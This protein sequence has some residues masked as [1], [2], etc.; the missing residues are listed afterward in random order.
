[1]QC[2]IRT[3]LINFGYKKRYYTRQNCLSLAWRNYTYFT[4][5]K[6]NYLLSVSCSTFWV[7]ESTVLIFPSSWKWNLFRFDAPKCKGGDESERIKL[8]SIKIIDFQLMVIEASYYLHEWSS[9]SLLIKESKNL[10]LK[11]QSP[12]VNF[13]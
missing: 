11:T 6:K 9:S 8:F 4:G 13:L 5:L 7:N 3:W 1:M 12:Q 2:L 10:S